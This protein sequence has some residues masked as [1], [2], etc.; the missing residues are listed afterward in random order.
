[1]LHCS[2]IC[3]SPKQ[4]LPPCVGGGFVQL[5]DRERTPPGL[6]D[7]L[8]TDHCPQEVQFPSTGSVKKTNMN[9]KMKINK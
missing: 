5:R 7:A 8:Q 2:V 3:E 6:H 1:M 9:T 4:F